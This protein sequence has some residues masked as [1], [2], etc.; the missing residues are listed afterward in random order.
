M[1]S[2][3]VR[4]LVCSSAIFIAGQKARESENTFADDLLVLARE[5]I[6]QEPS[7]RKETSQPMKNQYAHK[8]Q[9]QYYAAMASSALQSSPEEES[10]TKFWGCLVT[11]FG[12]HERQ[13]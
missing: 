3:Q 12:G 6:V 4:L 13:S 10:F 2:S 11:M 9:D 5:I 8:L 1:P 7:F